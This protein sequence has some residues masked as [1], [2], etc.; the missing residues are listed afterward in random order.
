MNWSFRMATLIDMPVQS[1][2]WAGLLVSA[3]ILGVQIFIIVVWWF[4]D[5]LVIFMIAI[6]MARNLMYFAGL[7]EGFMSS[8]RLL[9][10]SHVLMLYKMYDTVMFVLFVILVGVKL[11]TKPSFEVTDTDTGRDFIMQYWVSGRNFVQN[12]ALPYNWV[13]IP[14]LERVLVTT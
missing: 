9:S 4:F 11:F 5:G 12:G 1:L 14:S 6:I 10:E 13:S 7:L 2:Q 3:I 8:K